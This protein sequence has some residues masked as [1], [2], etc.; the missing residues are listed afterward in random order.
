M[1]VVH[2]RC[3]LLDVCRF[4]V[5]LFCWMAVCCFAAC[6]ALFV[7]VVRCWLLVA[8]CWLLS[9]VYGFVFAFVV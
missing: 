5:L 8:G 6:C 9:V 2:V 1:L 7:F 4:A 3:L